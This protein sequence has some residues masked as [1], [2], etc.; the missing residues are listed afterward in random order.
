[1]VNSS[2][3]GE[4]SKGFLIYVCFV[5]GDTNKQI[6]DSIK[7]IINL[8]IFEDKNRKM[9][10]NIVQAN[11]KILS[12]SQFTLSWNGSKGNRPS[13]DQSMPPLEAQVMYNKF[14][15]DLEHSGIN[16][17]TGIFGADMKVHSINDG[18]VTINLEFN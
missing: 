7:K 5:K 2:T 14:N 4:I 17:Q 9:N 15:L 10:N 11:G 6:S 3:V 8:R 13:F 16:I 12:I 18:P 1:M